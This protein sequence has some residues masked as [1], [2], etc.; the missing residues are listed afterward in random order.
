M[1]HHHVTV[2]ETAVG[3]FGMAGGVFCFCF[4]ALGGDC[5]GVISFI[6]TTMGICM[7]VGA[8]LCF[9][10]FPLLTSLT[11]PALLCSYA[12]RPRQV[13]SCSVLFVGFEYIIILHMIACFFPL[14][15]MSFFSPC[16]VL[17]LNAFRNLPEMQWEI[18]L[19][20][21]IA[22]FI[23]MVFSIPFSIHDVRC[24]S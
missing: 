22:S 13:F 1:N 3:V 5:C 11:P 16:A 23:R 24:T 19:E 7:F 14:L 6:I 18:F 17:S 15:S 8:V 10:H 2:R 9:F 20:A 21:L 12:S 4:W